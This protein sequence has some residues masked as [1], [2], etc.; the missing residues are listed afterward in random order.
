MRRPHNFYIEDNLWKEFRK[1]CL[2]KNK[3]AT[4]IIVNFIKN[5]VKKYEKR[6]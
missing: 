4:D 3:S 2:D 5:E 1:Y 6:K